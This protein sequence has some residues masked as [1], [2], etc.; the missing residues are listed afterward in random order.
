MEEVDGAG[1]QSQQANK[2]V[3]GLG[4]ISAACR[5]KTWPERDND[6]KLE[7]LRQELGRALNLCED[8]KRTVYALT[9]H[10]HGPGGELMV[11]IQERLGNIAQN[12]RSYVPMSLRDKE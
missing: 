8:L 3:G 9:N 2:V 1:A 12:M 6:G 10:Q 11:P 7:A 5:E 4:G